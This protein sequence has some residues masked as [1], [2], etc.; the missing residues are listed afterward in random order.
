[1]LWNSNSENVSGTT[2]VWKN[3]MH[4]GQYFNA[5]QTFKTHVPGGIVLAKE[6]LGK[7]LAEILGDKHGAEPCL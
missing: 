1:M 7:Q 4:G 3:K 6:R 2:A 5:L